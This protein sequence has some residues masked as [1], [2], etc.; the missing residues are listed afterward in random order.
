MA[1]NA[2]K[3]G[4]KKA[5]KKKKDKRKKHDWSDYK[6]GKKPKIVGV[7]E[8]VEIILTADG[9]KYNRDC[10]NHMEHIIEQY[11]LG[12]VKIQMPGS[13]TWITVTPCEGPEPVAEN[14]KEEAAA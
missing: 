11:A 13:N 9:K 8:N 6:D 5:I 12:K 14:S 2:V 1:S 10:K 7:R 4:T 3:K